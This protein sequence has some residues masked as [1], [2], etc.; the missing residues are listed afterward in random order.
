MSSFAVLEKSSQSTNSLR[1]LSNEKND[2]CLMDG[3]GDK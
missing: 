3:Q 2:V 1:A